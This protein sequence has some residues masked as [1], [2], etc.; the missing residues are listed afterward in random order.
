[1]T[2]FSIQALALVA[3]LIIGGCDQMA[4]ADTTNDPRAR[5]E[6][7]I[8]EALRSRGA[9]YSGLP[10]TNVAAVGPLAFTYNP[11][12]STIAVT[13]LIAEPTAWTLFPDRRPKIEQSVAALKDPNIGGRFQTD[14][15]EWMLDRKTG[16][17]T[18]GYVFPASADAR[19]LSDAAA[20]LERLYPDWSLHW[21]GAVADIVH[22]GAA[23]PTQ[24]I[25][26]DN[27][28]YR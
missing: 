16:K 18:L 3:S 2:R 10:D 11:Q 28:P 5:A 8:G 4:E 27:N 1:M 14:G 21:M 25:T 24:N 7:T 19:Q 20:S 22:E 12:Q 17:L 13:A 6:A 26:I 9:Q 23:V 15:A